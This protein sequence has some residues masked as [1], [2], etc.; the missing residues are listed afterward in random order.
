[1]AQELALV[2][3]AALSSL[4]W[5]AEVHFPASKGSVPTDI[6]APF[7]QSIEMDSEIFIFENEKNKFG[8]AE[9]TLKPQRLFCSLSSMFL[10]NFSAGSSDHETRSAVTLFL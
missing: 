3:S 1:L 8:S 10:S 7:A 6:N 4:Q 5:I 9:S 2:A